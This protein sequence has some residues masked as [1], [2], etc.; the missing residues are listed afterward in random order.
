MF[1]FKYLLLGKFS[2]SE[3]SIKIENIKCGEYT[4]K[5]KTTFFDINFWDK[6]YLLFSRINSFKL[7]KEIYSDEEKAESLMKISARGYKFLE[8]D[9]E[10][11]TM[12][13][14]DK[15]ISVDIVFIKN[16]NTYGEIVDYLGSKEYHRWRED[17][18]TKTILPIIGYIKNKKILKIGVVKIEL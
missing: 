2:S 5:R 17:V 12:V 8:E 10:P 13:C 9:E 16:F 1:D 18:T 7:I 4:R 15:E 11:F 14:E 6:V 3:G